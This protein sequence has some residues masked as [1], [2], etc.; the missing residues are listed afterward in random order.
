[1]GVMTFLTM[2]AAWLSVPFERFVPWNYNA[3]SQNSSK[4]RASDASIKK[5]QPSAI[6]KT[7]KTQ[8]YTITLGECKNEGDTLIRC[9]GFII[10]N[11]T[12]YRAVRVYCVPSGLSVAT[13]VDSGGTTWK[14]GG[15]SFGGEQ[16]E[17]W[18]ETL[19]APHVSYIYSV[20]FP[21][22][23]APQPLPPTETATYAQF[24]DFYI[25]DDEPQWQLL[26]RIRFTD[27]GIVSPW[28]LTCP[29]CLV[30]LC[31]FGVII[32]IVRKLFA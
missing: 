13:L 25:S 19:M 26:T 18:A 6:T 5:P 4:A 8:R 29:G 16:G 10:N 24:L 7:V 20:Q 1:M 28:R 2:V 21:N 31:I 32:F 3:A 27:L 22:V 12:E 15:C 11:T 9:S 30:C 23:R 14:S 17:R